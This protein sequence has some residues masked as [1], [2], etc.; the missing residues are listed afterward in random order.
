MS[1]E[2]KFLSVSKVIDAE[3]ST[4]L[5]SNVNGFQK[6]FVMSSAIDIIKNQLSDAVAVAQVNPKQ[7]A[8]VADNGCP[9]A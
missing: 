6:A 3:I 1:A 2:N 9:S 8:F 4:V 7:A 5:S